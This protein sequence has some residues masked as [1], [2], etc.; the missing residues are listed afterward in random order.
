MLETLGTAVLTLFILWCVFGVSVLGFIGIRA[1]PEVIG[2]AAGWLYRVALPRTPE[3]TVDEVSSWVSLYVVIAAAC[4][5][6]WALGYVL[7]AVFF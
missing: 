1:L 4:A 5:F 6:L 3:A 2:D 7:H